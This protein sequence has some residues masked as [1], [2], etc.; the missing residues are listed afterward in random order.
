M[1]DVQCKI[2][3]AVILLQG[4]IVC[5]CLHQSVSLF[6]GKKTGVFLW[7]GESHV[8]ISA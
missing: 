5:L 6:K 2:G 3:S 8:M 4:S 7:S 1:L